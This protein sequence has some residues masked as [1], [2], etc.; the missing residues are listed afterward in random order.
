MAKRKSKPK[1]QEQTDPWRDQFDELRLPF[2][3]AFY[4]SLDAWMEAEGDDT[5]ALQSGAI[6]IDPV[7]SIT[8]AK[9]TLSEIE[10]WL[11]GQADEFLEA[12]E[13]TGKEKVL[14]KRLAPGWLAQAMQSHL[15]AIQ[16]TLKQFKDAAQ[17]CVEYAQENNGIGGML[18]G[19]FKGWMNPIDGIATIFGEG[20]LNK[21]GSR[22]DKN[23]NRCATQLDEVVSTADAELDELV[24]TKWNTEIIT[25]AEDDDEKE[26]A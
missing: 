10:S 25:L 17:E 24:I 5:D 19:A 16:T 13:V 23:L 9:A 18:R 4:D 12:A 8:S 6:T 15:S 22:I 11:R 26:D 14:R 7:G 1:A 2:H 3:N 20:T 21:E